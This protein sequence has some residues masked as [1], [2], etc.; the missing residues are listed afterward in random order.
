MRV[1]LIVQPERFDFYSFLAAGKDIEWVL[2]WYEKPSQMVL[3]PVDLP[4]DFS[5]VR[6]WNEFTTP[7]ML[8][9]TIKPDRIIF[10]EIIDL[11]QIALNVTALKN[12]VPTFFMEH[13]AAGD[14]DAAAERIEVSKFDKS[15]LIYLLTRFRSSFSDIIRSKVF[16]YSALSGLGSLNSFVK[17]SFLPLKMLK[18]YPNKTLSQNIFE[19]RIPL[20]SIVFNKA[21]FEE[22]ALYSGAST[23][24]AVFGGV[25]FF[26]KYYNNSTAEKDYIIYNEACYLEEGLAGWT[27]EHHKEVAQ[28]LFDFAEKN[29]ITLYVKLHPRSNPVLWESYE[30]N[31]DY[32][33][34]LHSGDFTD[35]YLQSKLILSYSS[36]MLN[37]CLCAR[38][39]IV[40]LGWHPVPHI[41]GADFSD[42]G[43]CHVSLSPTE[44]LTNFDY[45]VNNNLSYLNEGAYNA[46]LDRFNTPFDGKASERILERIKNC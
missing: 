2:L 19:E 28:A 39:N 11:R 7:Q 9:D 42:Y 43:L 14:K 5:S 24:N 4:L 36:S 25:P 27:K 45:W 38:K 44:L 20:R 31:K 40:L 17:Y 18:G 35:L 15:K 21:N 32:V 22:Y 3:S 16:Y 33:T 12:K 23:E 30:F 37:G 1:L 10:Y 8:L 46:F 6:Y 26:D 29:K 41:F 34:I 13:G